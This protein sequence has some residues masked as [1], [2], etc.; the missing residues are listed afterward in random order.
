MPVAIVVNEGAPCAP[1]FAS[2]RNPRGSPDFFE[3][4]MSVVIKPILSVISDVQVFPSVV[5]V[6]T[7]ADALSPSGCGEPGSRGHVC[8]RAIV[9]VAVQMIGGRFAAGESFEGSAVHDKNIRP[10]VIVVIEDS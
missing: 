7:D 3:D 2:S 8:K 10:S 4:A 9:I 1:E 5:V 6:V